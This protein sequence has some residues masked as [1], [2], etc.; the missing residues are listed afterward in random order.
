MNSKVTIGHTL[1]G[2]GSEKVI[3]LHDWMGDA[4]NWEGTI[5][6]ID[7]DTFTYAFMDV[8]GYGK[9]KEISGQYTTTEIANDVFNLA[10]D[11]GW[12]QFHLVGHSMTGM[13]MQR[14]L[15]LDSAKRI[16]GLI[17]ITPVSAMGFPVDEETKQFFEQIIVNKEVASTAY[18]AFTSNKLSDTW[19]NQRTAN[20]HSVTDPKAMKGYLNMWLNE[21]FLAEIKGNEKPILI[22]YGREDHPGF[23]EKA[24]SGNF[25]HYPNVTFEGIT[26]SGHYPM[27]QTPVY[28]ISLIENY[29]RKHS[30]SH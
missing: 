20:L 30:Q 29:L 13:A 27:Q 23:Q 12:D 18:G 21:N 1:H 11:L 26:N 4:K 22:L 10:E 7:G 28:T 16:Q 14:A 5:P 6:F 17:L 25:G 9:S 15:L 8:R 24:L 2:H 19:K 3:A